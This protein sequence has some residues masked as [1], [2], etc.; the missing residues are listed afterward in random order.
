[1]QVF[2]IE[3]TKQ[4]HFAD[5]LNFWIPLLASLVTV[6]TLFT[7]IF[8]LTQS[9]IGANE[10]AK[11]ILIRNRRR[12][13]C[14]TLHKFGISRK[15]LRVTN[16]EFSKQAIRSGNHPSIQ[17]EIEWLSK[18]SNLTNSKW[19]PPIELNGFTVSG[20]PADQLFK[21]SDAYEKFSKSLRVQVI[22]SSSALME[23]QQNLASRMSKYLK[24]N[25]SFRLSKLGDLNQNK[26]QLHTNSMQIELTHPRFNFAPKY[27]I[28]DI[29]VIHTRNRTVVI[30]TNESEEV[31]R[32]YD[33]IAFRREEVT[34]NEIDVPEEKF[35]A[36]TN[37]FSSGRAFDGVLPALHDFHLQLDPSSGHLR[38]LLEV[39]EINFSAVVATH[40]FGTASVLGGTYDQLS[41]KAKDSDRLI[42]LSMFPLSSDGFLLAAQRSKDVGVAKLKYA[43]GVNGNLELQDRLGLKV[44]RDE[45]DLPDMILASVREAKEE[46]ALEVEVSRVQILGLGNLTYDEE[47]KTNVLLTIAPTELTVDQILEVS[48][49]ADLTEGAWELTGKFYKIAVPITSQEA[50]EL[51]Q[52]VIQSS[53]ATPHLVLALLA[54]CLPVMTQGLNEQLTE[55]EILDFWRDRINYLLKKRKR[56]LPPGV[57]EIER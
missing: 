49:H 6:T 15:N 45:F 17:S 48:K 47:E 38:L 19:K 18:L 2:A 29:S 57:E 8:V 10:I 3:M 33:P 41:Q 5:T 22:L 30:H 24:L 31:Q 7:T 46:L 52:W 56:G 27:Q 42:T 44:D 43:P 16:R 25:A 26:F 12:T 32:F 39:S 11:R 34:P 36:L 55:E 37:H 21:L 51:I 23:E 20:D 28:D 50:E 54:V 1:M 9:V 13:I 40:Y 14:A 35:N 4:V 53:E